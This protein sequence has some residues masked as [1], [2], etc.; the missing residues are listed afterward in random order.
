MRIGLRRESRLD[1]Q[2]V[3]LTP[4]GV[5][6]LVSDGHEV[7]VDSGAGTASGYA[8]IV[9]QQVGARVSHDPQEVLNSPIL[10]SLGLP[11]YFEPVADQCV[12]AYYHRPLDA[13]EL[14]VYGN[15]SAS[16]IALE[17]VRDAQGNRAL[18]AVMSRLAGQRAV[19][20]VVKWLGRPDREEVTWGATPGRLPRHLVVFGGGPAG[21]SAAWLGQS[22]GAK[23]T[24]VEPNRR[25]HPILTGYGLDVL[26]ELELLP[27]VLRAA[28]GVICSAIGDDGIPPTVLT[29]SL[30]S[31]LSCGTV[32]VDLAVTDGGSVE[33]LRP[34]TL[35]NPVQML[36]GG[37]VGIAVPNWASM[38]PQPASQGLTT[39]LMPVVR[40]VARW[41]VSET[42]RRYPGIAAGT[43]VLEGAFV[44]HAPVRMPEAVQS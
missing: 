31:M 2:R 30:L 26:D 8:D 44:G 38:S 24:I 15:R 18:L 22:L 25:L 11:E 36:D 13:N 10:V 28:D 4:A 19:S 32:V 17:R 23:I 39:Q 1:E 5:K 9:Y 43:H 20:A 3:A 33:G 34:T 12:M 7:V 27:K 42:L 21:T 29:R 41:G 35:A 14:K 37:V 6:S 16:A 40:R